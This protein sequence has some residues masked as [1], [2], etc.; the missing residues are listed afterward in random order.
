MSPSTQI[1]MQ[2]AD[3]LVNVSDTGPAQSGNP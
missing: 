1:R 2:A 3:A